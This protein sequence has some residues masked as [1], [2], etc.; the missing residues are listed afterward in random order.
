MKLNFIGGFL[1]LCVLTSCGST[2]GAA[3][4]ATQRQITFVNVKTGAECRGGFD[5]ATREA[6]VV[7]PEGTRLVGKFF[8]VNNARRTRSTVTGTE[9]A[10]GSGLSSAY[11]PGGSTLVNSSGTGFGTFSNSNESVT[12][13]T[14]GEGWA[15]L[16]SEDGK[17]VMEVKAMSNGMARAGYGAAEMND[18]RT[19]RVVW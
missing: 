8:S 3:R 12:P 4:Q 16:R 19:F 17:K 6:W 7:L 2:G 15:L 9:S 1:S 14:R 11:G 18:G 10:Y 13:A 5:L